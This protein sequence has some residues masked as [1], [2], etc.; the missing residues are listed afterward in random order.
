MSSGVF[1][2]AAGT[3]ALQDK[4]GS[5]DFRKEPGKNEGH[6]SMLERPADV[7]PY[8]RQLIQLSANY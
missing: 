4:V 2:F 7:T 8:L 5:S 6:G 1:S 3:M